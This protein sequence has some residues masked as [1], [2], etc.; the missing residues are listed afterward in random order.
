MKR[1]ETIVQEALGLFAGSDDAALLEQA[2]ARYLGKAG[3]LTELLKSL[4]K[5]PAAE[6]PA[7]GARINLAKE[8]LEA[9]LARRREDLAEQKLAQQP[10]GEA[11]D[12]SLPGRGISVGGLHP[13]TRTMERI[14]SLFASLGFAV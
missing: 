4:G 5:L 14:E 3:R 7:A 1:L 11:L 9:A 10:A 6:R 12:V 8:Q 2:K 13:I